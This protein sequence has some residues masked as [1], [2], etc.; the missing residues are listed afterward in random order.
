MKIGARFLELWLDTLGPD[1][2]FRPYSPGSLNFLRFLIQFV[3]IGTRVLSYGSELLLDLSSLNV[4]SN[5][6]DPKVKDSFEI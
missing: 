4:V 6:P 3:T 2:V 1:V 5:P